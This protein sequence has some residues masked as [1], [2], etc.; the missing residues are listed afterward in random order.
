MLKKYKNISLS[1]LAGLLAVSASV[2]LM[3]FMYGVLGVEV[4]M[5]EIIAIVSMPLLVAPT[6]TFISL[7]LVSKVYLL[8]KE[9]ETKDQ[10]LKSFTLSLKAANHIIRNLLNNV[11]LIKHSSKNNE[12][13]GKKVLEMLDENI[14]EAKSQMDILNKIEEPINPDAYKEI[15]PS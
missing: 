12:P 10:S 15:F 5:S 6:V 9:I 4:R 2:P 1:I 13:L 3:Y 14:E 11:M 8:E 7:R